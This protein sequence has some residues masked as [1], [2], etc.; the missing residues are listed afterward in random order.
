MEKARH[1]M[2]NPRSQGEERRAKEK[3]G[4][5]NHSQKTKIGLDQGIFPAR[6]IGETGWVLELM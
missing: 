6:G 3:N 5:R 2:E 1:L 4:L